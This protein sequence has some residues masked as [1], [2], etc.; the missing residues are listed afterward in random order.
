MKNNTTEIIIDID[1]Y[2]EIQNR[3][4]YIGEPAND[5]LRRVFN[6]KKMDDKVEEK[7]FQKLSPSGGLYC[8]NT[9]LPNGLKLRRFFK[10]IWHY[11]EVKNNAIIYNGKTFHSPSNAGVEASRTSVNGWIWWECEIEP[12][13][14]V[15][16]DALRKK[17]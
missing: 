4:N 16:L 3:I 8:S 17:R 10:G 6:L 9:F 14:W 2:K 15:I 11:A 12:N 13:K 7:P 1:V 5:V